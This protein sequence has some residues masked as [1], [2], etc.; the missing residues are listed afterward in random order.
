MSLSLHQHPEV[1]FG[2]A[3]VPHGRWGQETHLRPFLALP[4]N[5]LEGG[6]CEL[7]VLPKTQQELRAVLWPI[8][9]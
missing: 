5:S 9:E 1:Q 6:A 4:Q 7:P 8:L 2:K 3:E